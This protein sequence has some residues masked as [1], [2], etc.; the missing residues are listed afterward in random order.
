MAWLVGQGS[1]EWNGIITKQCGS[2]G[3]RPAQ[4]KMH[5][6]AC[7]WRTVLFQ[8]GWSDSRGS[9]TDVPLFSLPSPALMPHKG[10]EATGH[11]TRGV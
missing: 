7:V 1:G 8:S 4:C 11:V 6:A 5:S 2:R 10:S 3:L 9:P